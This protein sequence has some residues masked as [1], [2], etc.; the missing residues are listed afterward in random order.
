MNQAKTI[1]E[2]NNYTVDEA[3]NVY[4][5]SGRKLGTRVTPK[6]YVQTWLTQNGKTKY[7]FIH[8]LIAETFIDNPE[9]KKEVNHKDGNKLNNHVSNLEWVTR[10]ENISHAFNTGLYKSTENSPNSK[11]TNA[12]IVEIKEMISNGKSL[13]SIGKIYGVNHATIRH[14]KLGLTWKRLATV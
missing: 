11:L 14:I 1:K 10:L 9:G 13:N 6:W 5:L 12:N 3:G 4:H 7:R 2:F 8:R